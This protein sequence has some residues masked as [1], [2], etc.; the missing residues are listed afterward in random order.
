MNVCTV[1]LG[2]IAFV[3][4]LICILFV[5]ILGLV[6][7]IF[8]WYAS[9]FPRRRRHAEKRMEADQIINGL[10]QFNVADINKLIDKLISTSGRMIDGLK[11]EDRMRIDRLREIRDK[12]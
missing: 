10:K 7:V 11:E 9:G 8:F 4:T 12:I 5:W 2:R 6:G 3:P 1:V